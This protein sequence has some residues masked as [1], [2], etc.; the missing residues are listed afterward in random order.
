MKNTEIP[1]L[2]SQQQL[3]DAGYL[4]SNENWVIS[5]PTGAG[6]TRMGEWALIKAAAAGRRGVYL[7]P[8]KAIVEEKAADWCKR[9]IDYKIGLY[10][11]ET[12]R[13]SNRKTP[14]EEPILLMTP[15]KLSSY[16]HSW[17][18][19]LFWLAQIDV[20]VID[21]FHFMD[22]SHR[23]TGIE[24]LI[25]RM[26]RINPFVRFIGL[27]ATIPNAGELAVWLHAREFV[28]TWRPVPLTHKVVR[29]KK[30]DQKIELLQAEINKTIRMGGQ[31][32]VFVNSRRRCE[33]LSLQLNECGFRAAFYHAGLDFKHRH[34]RSTEMQTQEID[35]L[36]ATSS[37][38]MG[39]N[40][41]A[42]KVIIYDSYLFDGSRFGPLSGRRYLQF[43]G[44]AGRH[45]YDDTG[46]SVIFLPVWH[47]NADLYQN[48][49][50]EP[51]ESGFSNHAAFQKEI[52]TEVATRLSISVAH[53]KENFVSRTF[54]N[55]ISKSP[56]IS[57]LVD[58][59][60]TANL[61]KHSGED[62]EYLS[63]TSLG[64]IATQM[65][66]SP[67]TI[68]IMDQFQQ[69]INTPSFLDCLIAL[70]LCPEL[71]PKIPFSFEHIDEMGDTMLNCPSVLLD[72]I[73]DRTVSLSPLKYSTKALLSSIK[74]A[75]ILMCHTTGEPIDS[76]AT[77]FDC[78][79]IDI[80]LLKRNC[81]WLLAVALRV[82]AVRWRQQWFLEHGKD[83]EKKCPVSIHE[84]LIKQL[85]TMVRYGLPQEACQLASVKKIG[86]KRSFSLFHNGITDLEKLAKTPP[87]TIA[88][89]IRLKPSIC[90]TLQT[91]ALIML[92]EQNAENYTPMPEVQ[93]SL[94][95]D[96]VLEK[97]P[98]QID[99]YRLRR[100]LD[101]KIV[102]H[103]D[104]CMQIE[105]GTEPHRIQITYLAPGNREYKC[106]CAD[107]AKG[108]L[109][110]H[111]MRA[112]LE[113]G[114]GKGLIHALQAFQNKEHPPL[115][116]A[117]G[118]LWIQ[119]SGLYDRYE[120]RFTD[121]HGKKFLEQSIA[122]KRWKR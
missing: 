23:G 108:N 32:L 122:A 96:Q 4:D 46:E 43:A 33:R 54:N 75:L 53:I 24:S 97:W 68:Q 121:Y 77:R 80:Q 8:L 92:H 3:I 10:T 6:K 95:P 116:Y 41:P 89:I 82:F 66:V 115:R 118:H 55:C 22:D 18:K 67:A 62:D 36:I 81:D 71:S 7:A 51:I 42:R 93:Q 52:I 19:N 73:T 63:E 37:L 103:S 40:Y 104:E 100:A 90:Q 39:V 74:T 85:I 112:R 25:G 1:L 120:E 76:L 88:V 47:K 65:D 102:H 91:D 86:S 11:G 105:G 56:D 79:P 98:K 119:D 5:A 84:Q 69:K 49:T 110:K 60:I 13:I 48:G 34:I 45:G 31:V 83:T 12:T 61:L 113:N 64:R 99:P 27:S 38:E 59:L 101:L 14:K 58:K 30:V 29:F 35:V 15:E 28:T 106:D 117:I 107:A 57:P 109:C 87:G 70:C 50:P 44:R 20:V 111:V 114:D 72:S 21:E 26:Q 2:K 94:P 78:Y 17:K 9:Y 16:L